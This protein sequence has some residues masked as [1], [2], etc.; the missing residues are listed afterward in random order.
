[1]AS[2][3]EAYSNE[4]QEIIDPELAYDLYWAGI[5]TDK[6]NFSCPSDK[7]NARVTC[8]NLDQEKQ[9]MHQSPHFRGYK[10][11]DECDA[12]LHL[13]KKTGIETPGQSAQSKFVKNDAVSDVFNLKRPKNQFAKKEPSGI[14]PNKVQKRSSRKGKNTNGEEF[15]GGSEY[16]SVRSLVSKFIRY[17]KDDSLSEHKVN[18]SGTDLAYK[19]LFKGVYQQPIEALPNENLV[20]WGV[21]FI[22]FLS[23]KECYKITFGETL[24]SKDTQARPSFFIPKKKIEEY[25]VRNLVMKRLEKISSLDDKRAF[26]F[27]YSRPHA[28][29]ESYINFN[30][31]SLDYLEIRYLDL[32]EDLKKKT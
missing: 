25:P 17:K 7:C 32:F 3:E 2:L 21:A 9:D 10:H 1:M 19:S 31:E 16:Y 29:G 14:D 8:I 22:D 26:V 23:N 5:I 6:S 13:D 15:Y 28:S 12:T 18:I 24:K 30:L 4:Y 20:Y 27:I 11:S